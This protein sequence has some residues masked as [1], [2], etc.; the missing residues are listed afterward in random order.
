[1]NDGKKNMSEKLCIYYIKIC[2]FPFLPHGSDD[3]I[4]NM[5]I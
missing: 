5:L 4:I 3:V 2:L 1:M